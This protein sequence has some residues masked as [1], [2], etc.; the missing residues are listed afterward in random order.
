MFQVRFFRSV[1]LFPLLAIV[2]LISLFI[3]LAIEGG[4]L[5]SKIFFPLL[6]NLSLIAFL[7]SVV[8]FFPLSMISSK[9]HIAKKGFVVTSYILTATLWTL[10]FIVS[11]NTWGVAGILIGLFL[12]GIGVIPVAFLATLLTMQ[13]HILSQLILLL[14]AVYLTRSYS[15]RVGVKRVRLRKKEKQPF[16]GEDV[17]NADY[18]EV[19]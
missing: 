16:D 10:S 14:A 18:E 13:W 8:V 9:K 12:F 4:F 1:A 6:S 3:V 17:E 7:A 19:D 2:I 15:Q 11:Y 5:V